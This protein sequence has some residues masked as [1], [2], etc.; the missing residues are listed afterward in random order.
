[1]PVVILRFSAIYG[2]RERAV[3]RLFQMVRRG[4]AVTV[5][6]WERDVSLV[7]VADAVQ[8]LLAAATAPGAA[9]RTY[10][11]AHPEPVRWSDFA[12]SV[13]DAV[14]RA[15]RLV[16]IGPGIARLVAIAAEE[17]SRLRG[18]VAIL[19][20]DRVREVSQERWVCDA[21]PAME[22][23]GYRP[24]FA[25]WRGVAATAAWYREEGWL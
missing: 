20:R 1:V 7:Y 10:C 25:A 3:L 22:E 23:I 17:S 9:G 8:A 19:N 6:S 13:G 5:G 15:P 21:R 16:S 18:R 11:I 4:L 12:R 24:V 2:P 14:G